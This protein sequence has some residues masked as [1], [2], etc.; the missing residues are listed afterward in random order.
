M[1]RKNKAFTLAEVL[2][3]LGIIGV[4]AALTIPILINNATEQKYVVAWKKAYST[5]E[6]AQKSI[7]ADNGGDLKGGFGPIT[8]DAAGGNNFKAG[9]LPYLSVAKSCDAGKAVAEGCYNASFKSLDGSA[10]SGYVNHP[11]SPTLILSNGALVLFYPGMCGGTLCSDSYLFIDVDGQKGP[12]TIGKDVF[13]MRYS[14]SL[15]RFVLERQ[16]T[17][18]CSGIGWYCGAYYLLK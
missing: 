2:I 14:I 15:S 7:A 17:I 3:T 18:A 12:N 13:L 5:M 9:W 6:Q 11:Y 4:V 1:L 10:I 8:W 16:A